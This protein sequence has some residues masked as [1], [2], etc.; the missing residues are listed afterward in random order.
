MNIIRELHKTRPTK[1][2]A[3]LRLGAAKDYLILEENPLR[4]SGIPERL[5]GSL[6]SRVRSFEVVGLGWSRSLISSV[7]RLR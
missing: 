6:Q 4:G 1:K 2:M 3:T 5:P 7:G